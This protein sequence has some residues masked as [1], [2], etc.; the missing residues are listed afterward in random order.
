M[1]DD[2]GLTSADYPELVEGRGGEK[3]L[4]HGNLVLLGTLTINQ[5]Q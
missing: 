1:A 5:P 2:T 4:H 3:S